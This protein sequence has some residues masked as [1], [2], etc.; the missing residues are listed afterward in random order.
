M[1]EGLFLLRKCVFLLLIVALL[2][3]T[4][5]AS[6]EPEAFHCMLVPRL[7]STGELEPPFSRWATELVALFQPEIHWASWPEGQAMLVDIW[8]G[9]LFAFSF[10]LLAE[11]D[12][13]AAQT[14]LMDYEWMI[15]PEQLAGDARALLG[16]VAET[17]APQGEWPLADC[18]LLIQAQRGADQ[19]SSAAESVRRLGGMAEGDVRD[20]THAVAAVFDTVAEVSRRNPAGAPLVSTFVDHQAPYLVPGTIESDWP[21]ADPDIIARFISMIP[22]TLFQTICGLEP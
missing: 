18:T 21:L 14:S 22:G 6:P 3:S 13:I 9:N 1:R 8:V 20:R 7:E 11:G 10:E 5:H 4:C 17:F 12:R 2:P 16:L 15:L 19:L